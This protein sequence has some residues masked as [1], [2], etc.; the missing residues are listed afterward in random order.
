MAQKSGES[1]G[2]CHLKHGSPIRTLDRDIHSS[3]R[4]GT[5]AINVPTSTSPQSDVSRETLR[6]RSLTESTDMFGLQHQNRPESYPQVDAL[7]EPNLPVSPAHSASLA[8]FT[9]IHKMVYNLII[10]DAEISAWD[11][12]TTLRG[13]HATGTE[14]VSR[15]TFATRV[16]RQ[17]HVIG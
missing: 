13:E 6:M 15:E 17:I 11:C 16:S 4:F 7:R 10:M 3:V 8:L 12:S 1:I 14:H 9:A 2:M 5:S